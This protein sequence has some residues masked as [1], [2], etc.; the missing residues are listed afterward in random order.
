MDQGHP[1]D[2]QTVKFVVSCSVVSKQVEV[3]TIL[4]SVESKGP[5]LHAGICRVF[6]CYVLLEILHNVV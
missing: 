6:V 5:W 4:L 3:S 2:N 1:I